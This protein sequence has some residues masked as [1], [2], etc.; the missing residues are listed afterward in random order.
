[1]T[2][3]W[4]RPPQQ[5]PTPQSPA[6][7][8][9]T[10]QIPQRGQ[11]PDPATHRL[12]HQSHGSDPATQQAPAAPP[13]Q[14][15]PPPE[16]HPPAAPAGGDGPPPAKGSFVKRIFRDPLSIVLVLVIVVALAIAGLVGVELYAR[17]RGNDVVAAATACV[18]QDS[19]SASFGASPFLIQHLSKHYSNISIETA[20]NQIRDAKGMKAQIEIDDVRLADSG[21]SKGTIGS[22]EATITWTAD[23]IKQTI[24]NSIPLIGSFVTGVKTNPS[25]GTIELEGALGSIVTKPQVANDGIA[26]EVQELTG[27]G[28]TLPRETV[29]PALDLFS[30]QLTKNYPLGIHADSVEVTDSGV[31]S[32]FSTQ[33]A[34]IPAGG[35]DPCFAGV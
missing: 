28:F 14:S 7:E 26:L 17:D 35:E 34:T 3:P 9:P 22:L 1:M 25:D 27:L 21:N 18:V 29:Q 30:E 32:K 10:Q 11:Y 13:P 24:Q 12:A 23:G 2:D 31:I 16:H 6:G 19:A 33:N 4:A 20:G 15:Y 5:P 8:P